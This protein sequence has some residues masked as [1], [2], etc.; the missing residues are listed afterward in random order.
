MTVVPLSVVIPARDASATLPR[1]LEALR[2]AAPAGTE[3]VVVDD[4]STDDTGEIAR[5]FGAS[6]VPREQPGGPARARNAGLARSAGPIV[7]F[8]D[9]D[10]EVAPDALDRVLKAFAEDPGLSGVFGSYDDA[11][12]AGTLVS[13]Y[14]NLLHHFVHQHAH[15]ESTTFWAGL[16]AARRPALEDCGGFDERYTRPSIEDIVLGARLTAKGHRIRLDKHLRGTHLKR[17]TL[18]AVIRTDILA[19]ARPW[20]R[21]L[22][23]DGALPR[24]LNLQRRHRASGVLVW[25]TVGFA[26]G[27]AAMPSWRLG[28]AVV[29]LCALCGLAALN[30]DFYRFLAA[31]RGVRFAVAAFPLH[32]LYYA[33]AA[34]TF[35]WCCLEY[36]A[37][38]VMRRTPPHG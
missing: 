10:V 24:D 31:R 30:L 16:G 14:R 20:S 6:V 27:A 33:Y 25:L 7:L 28:M 19:R 3:V 18:P 29:S 9:A 8:V 23:R 4:G 36:G 2:R 21:L 38:R 12:S 13:D 22:L 17:W 26:M 5:R 37:Y 35:A 1:C 15:T 32:A 34:G 11:P